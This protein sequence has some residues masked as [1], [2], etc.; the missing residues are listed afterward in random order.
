MYC[1][2]DVSG[3]PVYVSG[4]SCAPSCSGPGVAK[5]C[6]PNA[7]N[8]CEAN[9]YCMTFTVNYGV[10]VPSTGSGTGK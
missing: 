9:E 8:Q 10:C 4:V 6:N 1:C 5:V 7:Q 2:A 3:S